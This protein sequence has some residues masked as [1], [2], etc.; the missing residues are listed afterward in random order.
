MSQ[1]I[2]NSKNLDDSNFQLY[3]TKRSRL[4]NFMEHAWYIYLYVI[5]ST[6]C[7]EQKKHH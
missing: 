5:Y 7:R 1:N 6:T 2:I 4:F 3:L